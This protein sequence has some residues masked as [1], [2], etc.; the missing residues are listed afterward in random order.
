MKKKTILILLIVAVLAGGFLGLNAI[1]NSK[2]KKIVYKK[3]AAKRGLVEAVVTT[4]GTVNPIETINV[5]SQVSGKVDKLYVDYNS[6]VTK[7]QVVAEIDQ[8][9]L[10]VKVNQYEASYNSY[11]ASLESSKITLET[12]K[13]KFERAK[14]LFDK[15][16]ISYEEMDT[17][18]ANYLSAKSDVVA[19]EAR[20]AQAK[21]T[22]D[23]GKVDLSYSIIKSPV[24]GIVISREVTL[25]QTLQAGYTV[26]VLFKV[27]PSL[28]KMQVECSV[29][30]AD[31]GKVKEGQMVKFTVDAY[32]EENFTG[33]VKQ[34]RYSPTTTSNVVTYITVVN[35]D[36]PELKL[37][38]GMT[39]TV[40][41]IVG[42]S[43]KDALL[44]PNT[45]LR[46]TPTLSE[47]EMKKMFAEMRGR[48]E[49]HRA[50]QGGEAP[51]Q[52]GQMGRPSGPMGDPGQAGQ[53]VQRKQPS[54]VWIEDANGKLRMAFVRTGVT[55]G[56][57]IEVLNGDVKE[58]D[59]II[60]GAGTA[61]TAATTS[62]QQNRQGPPP[63]MFR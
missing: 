13:K 15:K 52:P 47:K 17:A 19:N 62:Q 54:R 10:I 35:V 11:K 56:T 22:L 14:S 5:G 45:A 25:G 39:A 41:I 53:G 63:M 34:V 42:A 59:E 28:T 26:P 4:T 18:E 20:L 44:V 31:I 43:A 9:Q 2:A 30:E 12:T 1:K 58:G 61:A 32:L 33:V 7:G 55:D 23:Q 57:H 21:S 51:G 29:D 6:I 49:A 50:Q 24:D 60:T 16:L 27:A 3:E 36:N 38:P 40:S 8:E 37:R 48:M 46:F